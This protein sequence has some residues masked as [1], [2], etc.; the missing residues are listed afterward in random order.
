[1]PADCGESV[2]QFSHSLLGFKMQDD[3]PRAS[4]AGV[5]AWISV[6]DPVRGSGPRREQSPLPPEGTQPSRRAKWVDSSVKTL[7]LGEIR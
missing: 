5:D 1:M 6:D 2:R 7:R 4:S 3:L